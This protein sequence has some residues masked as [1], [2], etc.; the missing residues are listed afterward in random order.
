TRPVILVIVLRGIP[1]AHRFD[2]RDNAPAMAGVV[3]VDR[4]LRPRFLLVFLREKRR[5]ILRADVI[6]LPVE[7]GRIVGGEEDVE[8][9]VIADVLV[10]EGDADRFGMAGIAAAHLLVG[11]IG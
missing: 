5:T 11:G 6:A 8:E 4:R 3:A 2:R 1:V 9:V 7:L 10:I